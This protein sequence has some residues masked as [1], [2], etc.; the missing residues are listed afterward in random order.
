MEPQIVDYYNEYPHSINV[1]DKMNEELSDL[2]EENDML[3]KK[4]EEQKDPIVIYKNEQELENVKEKVYE[5]FYNALHKTG[6]IPGFIHPRLMYIL[7]D[8]LDHLLKNNRL[9]IKINKWIYGKSYEIQSFIE[10]T[11]EPLHERGY[12]SY[13]LIYDITIKYINDI[14][15]NESG[16]G[17]VKYRCIHCNEIN[18]YSDCGCNNSESSEYDYESFEE[19]F[20]Y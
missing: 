16:H 6:L 11:I 12:L 15:W 4:L 14:L 10:S 17:I 3:K 18:M 2:Q 8:L 20:D 5:K 9:N 13:N 19:D 1:I 7:G